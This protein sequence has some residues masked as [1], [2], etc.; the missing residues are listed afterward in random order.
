MANYTVNVTQYLT[1][2]VQA[3]TLEEAE[4]FVRNE[5]GAEWAEHQIEQSFEYEVEEH[6]AVPVSWLDKHFNPVD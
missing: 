1:F 5:E 6:N 4:D 3:N 2:Y